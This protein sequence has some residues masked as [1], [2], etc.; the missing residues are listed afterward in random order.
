MAYRQAV[1]QPRPTL[2]HTWLST[3]PVSTLELLNHERRSSDRAGFR[4]GSFGQQYPKRG[5][6]GGKGCAGNE[7]PIDY[8]AAAPFP[9][10][11][12]PCTK[13]GKLE[14]K[15]TRSSARSL[16]RKFRWR[17][18]SDLLRGRW[19]KSVLKARS[20]GR[21]LKDPSARVPVPVTDRLHC[22]R[23]LARQPHP[24]QAGQV[25]DL[26]DPVHC[27][28]HQV[29]IKHRSPDILNLRQEASRWP[30]E[31]ATVDLG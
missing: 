4:H 30:S 23:G 15:P 3:L 9:V 20:V 2:I 5:R 18:R 29:P 24:R 26:V 25:I 27:A 17:R 1:L 16:S 28:V 31:P 8:H 13:R 14:R 22:L 6:K 10:S 21:F 19:C 11:K 7:N 12:E